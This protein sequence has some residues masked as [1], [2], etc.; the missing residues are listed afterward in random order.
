MKVCRRSG[1][2]SQQPRTSGL[3]CPRGR[4]GFQ[5]AKEVGFGAEASNPAMEGLD[6]P[7]L[8][9]VMVVPPFVANLILPAHIL[10]FMHIFYCIF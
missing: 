4:D 8:M 2:D 3:P 9:V 10:L 1:N 6:P 5:G 7:P